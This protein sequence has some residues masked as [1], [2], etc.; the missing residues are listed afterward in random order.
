ME[1]K[2]ETKKSKSLVKKAKKIRSMIMMTL[3]CVLMMSA[4]TYAWF[5]LSN[6]SKVSNMTMTVGD[7]T[8]LQIADYTEGDTSGPADATKWG[9]ATT[10]VTL[11]GKL[12]P[13]HSANG[14]D[15]YEPEYDPDDG[16]V[17][18]IKTA[19]SDK[20][21]TSKTEENAEGYYA[22]HEFWIRAQGADGGKTDVQLTPGNNLQNGI[23]S[24]S[25][26]GTFSLSKNVAADKIL[27]SAAVRISLDNKGT[28]TIF[29]P[30][31]NFN[32]IA[33]AVAQDKSNTAITSGT[34]TQD[35]ST[36][37]ITPENNVVF[38]LDNNVATKIIVR[39]W[40]EG[41]DQQCGNEI[42]SKDIVSQLA[43]SGKAHTENSPTP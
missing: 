24:E 3:L 20:K 35:N 38:T 5:T 14:I 12:L 18:A 37:V 7:A 39:L 10:P 43:F 42:S 2:Q 25:A 6:T 9:A 22:E 8:G 26:T 1:K 17:K 23:Y 13:A 31:N 15:F 4:A 33:T 11:N 29:E 27:P 21:I 40:L 30:N 19:A 32:T 41:T 34:I 28:A 36:G 16:S